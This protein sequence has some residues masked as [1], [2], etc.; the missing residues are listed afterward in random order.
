MILDLA[1]I[2]LVIVI[3]IPEV[4]AAPQTFVRELLLN[5]IRRAEIF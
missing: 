5:R 2:S 1:K 3:A 4:L